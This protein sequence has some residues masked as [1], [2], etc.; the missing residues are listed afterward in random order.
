MLDD[1][2]KLETCFDNL[3]FF[4]FSKEKQERKIIEISENIF[5]NFAKLENVPD[6][7]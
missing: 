1:I 5:Y 2:V 7:T 3:C 4:F 6:F